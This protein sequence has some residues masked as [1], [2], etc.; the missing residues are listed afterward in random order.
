MVT[1]Q[2]LPIATY[3]VVKPILQIKKGV[4]YFDLFSPI[5]RRQSAKDNTDKSTPSEGK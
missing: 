2:L 4:L 3:L 1:I 5:T